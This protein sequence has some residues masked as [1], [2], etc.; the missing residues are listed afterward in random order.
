MKINN[1]A[2]HQ[3]ITYRYCSEN[4]NSMLFNQPVISNIPSSMCNQSQLHQ[5]LSVNEYENG[6]AKQF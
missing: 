2:S 1:P 5:D 3:I 6:E 4:L